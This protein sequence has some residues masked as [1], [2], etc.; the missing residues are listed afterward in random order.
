LSPLSTERD[1]RR[2]HSFVGIERWRIARGLVYDLASKLVHVCRALARAVRHTEGVAASSSE[3]TC[4]VSRGLKRQSDSGDDRVV[5]FTALREGQH[6]LV[7]F[8]L[9]KL[10]VCGN[11]GLSLWYDN[12]IASAPHPNGVRS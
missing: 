2:V 3:N 4:Q 5:L 10:A 11:F 7:V 12:R 8:S 9:R 6:D 1:R